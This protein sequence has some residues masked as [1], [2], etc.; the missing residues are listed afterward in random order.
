MIILTKNAHWRNYSTCN[1]L[2]NYP[3]FAPCISSSSRQVCGRLNTNACFCLFLCVEADSSDCKVAR[4]TFN[5]TLTYNVIIAFTHRLDYLFLPDHENLALKEKENMITKNAS[6]TTETVVC[7]LRRT[8]VV[9]R[10]NSNSKSLPT[11]IP[12]CQILEV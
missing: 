2:Y 9:I 5:I 4:L 12:S 3:T 8:H 1:Y 10:Q 11:V 6:M 7:F